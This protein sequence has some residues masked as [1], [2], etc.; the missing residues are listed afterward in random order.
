MINL[1]RL[2]GEEFWLN[3]HH[4]EYIEKTPDTS[5]ALLSG[6]RIT[7]LEAVHTVIDR[8]VEYRRLIGAFK[9]EE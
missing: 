6:K 5:I 7:V 8:I 9:N 3:P 2:N 1:T 4:I